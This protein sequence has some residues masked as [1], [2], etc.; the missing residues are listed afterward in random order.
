[1]EKLRKIAVM[2]SSFFLINSARAE[3]LEDVFYQSGRFYVVVA[4]LAIIML[5][6]FVYLLRMDV[7]VRRMEKENKK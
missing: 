4:I 1:M 2:I 6:L 7:R 3:G 5:L